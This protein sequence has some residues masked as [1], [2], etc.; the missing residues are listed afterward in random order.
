MPGQTRTH[1]DG[2][3]VSEGHE[4][5]QVVKV[6]MAEEELGAP[7]KRRLVLGPRRV[8]GGHAHSET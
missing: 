2:H 4:V 7:Q 6:V 8:L 3:K 1:T 5:A